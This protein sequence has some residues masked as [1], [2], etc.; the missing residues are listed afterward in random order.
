MNPYH[1]AGVDRWFDAEIPGA[2]V[3]WRL[4][5]WLYEAAGPVLK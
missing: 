3:E 5:Q 4:A 2:I 1:W